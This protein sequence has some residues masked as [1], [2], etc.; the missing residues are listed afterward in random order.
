MAMMRMLWIGLLSSVASAA[1]ANN[2]TVL[3]LTAADLERLGVT[4]G[5]PKQVAEIEIASGPAEVV[6]PPAKQAVVSSTVGGVLSRTLVAE[7]DS[8]VTGQALA[9]ISSADLLD[10]QSEYFDA[11]MSAELA[12][13]QLARDRGL[14]A[15][16]II[17]ERRLQ[18]SSAVARAASAA[19]EQHR[20]QL[21]LAG[22]TDR[23]LAALVEDG[24]LSSSLELTAPF[25]AVVIQQ[26][27]SLG[28]RVN[29]LDP[30]YRVADL[31]ELWL[32][33]HVPQE[34]AQRVE[35]GMRV[36]G[37]AGGRQ[38][39]ATVTHVGRVVDP[40]SQTVMVRASF[41]NE[42]RVLR[43]GQF[44]TTRVLDAGQ[45][46]SVLA[47]PTA[48][49]VR[50]DDGAYVFV[51]QSDGIAPIAAEILADGGTRAYVRGLESGMAIAVTGVAA[52]KSVWMAGEAEGE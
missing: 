25:D 3:S 12:D 51:R 17:A 9:E 34:Q 19:L 31:A 45:G 40:A 20:Q 26:L 13:A 48:A 15:D 29:A 7:G 23:E 28:T 18:E 49:I 42:S 5:T 37:L 16:G 4:L 24:T 8:V 2:N 6:I 21:V 38:V 30:V 11:A 39:E 50:V 33:I 36:V 32:E 52:L 1:L 10:A 14:L 22:M 27:S 44:L 43:A 41:A 46:P 35:P 47:V